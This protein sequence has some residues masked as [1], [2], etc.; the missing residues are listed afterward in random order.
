MP[1]ALI[2]SIYLIAAILAIGALYVGQEFFFPLLFA[3][4]L[5]IT[6]RSPVRAAIRRGVPVS[7]AAVSLGLALVATL[8]VGYLSLAEPVAR[9]VD[10]F[11]SIRMELEQKLRPVREPVEDV[12]QASE[13]L[14]S[15]TKT[16][17]ESDVQ[18]VVI[19]Q[20][21][22]LTQAAGALIQ[23][24]SILSVTIVLTIF[25]L[26]LR[27]P[28]VS[29]AAAF[30]PTWA[31]RR[32]A[33]ATWTRVEKQVSHYL[34]TISLINSGL[35]LAVGLA[36]WGF[37]MPAP[38]LWGVM[39][40]LLNF[41]PFVGAIVGAVIV[42]LVAIVS[43]DHIDYAILVPLAFL[44]LTTIE[45]NF[46]T[47]AIIGQRLQVT[48][49]SVIVALTFWGVLWGFAGLLVAVPVLVVL[50]SLSENSPRLAPLRAILTP[51]RNFR[52]AWLSRFRS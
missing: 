26:L 35:G 32:H 21:Q 9:F 17:Q 2:F 52:V 41:L 24:F 34:L 39:A 46:V 3:L 15:L 40:A 50:R 8:I 23:I 44:T 47:P 20:P 19:R 16:D 51:R 25:L 6:F 11:P 29:L 27:S 36:M 10:D 12:Q 22:F 37:G 33:I 38:H 42:G 31:Q 30:A 5:T 28:I 45:G 48:T 49:A 18:E 7:I 14:E 43:F 4:L 13:E 1:R